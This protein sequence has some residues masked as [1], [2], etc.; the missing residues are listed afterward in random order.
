[1]K[2]K[3]K[4][5]SFL[6]NRLLLALIG[7]LIIV[8]LLGTYEILGF[9]KTKSNI[10]VGLKAQNQA[11]QQEQTYL[12]SAKKEISRYSGLQQIAESIVPQDK[13]QAETVREIV[14]IAQT[15]GITLSGITFPSSSLGSTTGGKATS[16]LSLSQLTAVTGIPGVYVLPIEVDDSTNGVS[17][18][19]FYNFLSALEQNRRTSLVTSLS[20]QPVTGGL[21]TFSLTINEYIRPQ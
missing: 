3:V 6:L 4:L 16:T 10:L 2:E 15:N 20:I 17:Y 1:M 21:I 7:L 14:N 18:Q 11:L 8:A 19:S 5:D 12:V 13:D 9:L